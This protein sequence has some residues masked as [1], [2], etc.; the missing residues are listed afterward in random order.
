[1]DHNEDDYFQL[2][3]SNKKDTMQDTA[4]S[5]RDGS[6]GL[7]KVVAVVASGG[8]P[9]HKSSGNE[10]GADRMQR[11]QAA[12]QSALNNSSLNNMTIQR[13]YEKVSSGT[14]ALVDQGALD[15]LKKI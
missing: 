9:N 5:L 10:Y 13:N 14:S 8:R 1:M 2:S 3:K 4:K 11:A 15:R 7:S 6:K 12:N